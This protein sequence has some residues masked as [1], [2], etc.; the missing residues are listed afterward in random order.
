[1]LLGELQ[2]SLVLFLLGQS[3][4]A[5]EQWK[6]LVDLVCR[7]EDLLHGIGDATRLLRGATTVLPSPTTTA[8]A[9][10]TGSSTSATTS[11]TSTTAEASVLA[12]AYAV[13][14]DQLAQVPTDFFQGQLSNQNFLRRALQTLVEFAETDS[15][16]TTAAPAPVPHSVKRAV[17]ALRML[18]VQR[19]KWDVR[20]HSQPPDPDD[21]PV[22]VML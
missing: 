12:A 13:L 16:E 5:F 1:M 4:E 21:A 11:T 7:C 8:T 19:F 14:H 9:A 10:A 18:C 20:P 6:L 3:L 15:V 17:A 22:V 2:L